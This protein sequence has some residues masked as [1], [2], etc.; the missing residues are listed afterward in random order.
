LAR[1]AWKATTAIQECV[2]E[3]RRIMANITFN[4]CHGGLQKVREAEHFEVALTEARLLN[5]R[6]LG[7]LVPLKASQI[8]QR[9]RMILVILT[10]T[11]I[12]QTSPRVGRV[13]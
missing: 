8:H 3:M 5:V 12:L 7:M 4:L 2:D 6:V 13:E 9:A 11:W 1:E 10:P